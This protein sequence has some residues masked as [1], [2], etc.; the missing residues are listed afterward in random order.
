MT[1]NRFVKGEPSA[2]KTGRV[3]VKQPKFCEIP[4]CKTRWVPPPIGS[5][6][7][8][9]GRHV[10]GAAHMLIDDG[11][12]VRRGIC[13]DHYVQGLIRAG[14]H[15]SEHLVDADGRYDPIK[16]RAHWDSLA[17]IEIAEATK[18]TCYGRAEV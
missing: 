6:A 9:H 1:S 12:G 15:G 16:V 17:R 3:D 10:C 4:G 7:N 13:A 8:D 2:T 11:I 14:K 18:R 5:P